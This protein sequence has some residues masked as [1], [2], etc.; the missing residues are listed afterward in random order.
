MHRNSFSFTADFTLR[1]KF[2]LFEET[3]EIPRGA[4]DAANVPR[5]STGSSSTWSVKF[6]YNYGE[7]NIRDNYRKTDSTFRA[8]VALNFSLTPTTRVSYSQTY[9]FVRA[10]TL[11]ASIRLE[12]KIHC[13]TGSLFWV[14]IGSNRGFGF[15]LAVTEL[16]DIE[17][18]KNAG[19]GTGPSV[20]DL[21]GQ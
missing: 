6:Q 2:R 21:F 11:N 7:T 19:R 1:G 16:P 4:Q 18:K 20:S 3:E 17:I 14:P 12:R 13:W 9:D 10:K 15:R 8:S 5:P